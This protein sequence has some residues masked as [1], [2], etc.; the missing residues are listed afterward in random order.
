MPRRPRKFEVIVVSITESD[1]HLRK[2]IRRLLA[3]REQKREEAS[4]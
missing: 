1:E 4:K 2:V 3:V